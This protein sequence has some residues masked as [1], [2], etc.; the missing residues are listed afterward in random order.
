M[1]SFVESAVRS[2]IAPGTWLQTPDTY[3]SSPFQVSTIDSDGI[4]LPFGKKKTPTRVTWECLEGI[5]A[6]LKGKE[7]VEIGTVYD[8]G[9]KPDTLDGYLEGWI[10]RGTAGWVAA[11]LEKAAIVG[12]NR[13]RP[14]RVRL[15]L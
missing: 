6:F 7:W 3:K 9:A 12:I 11:V 15:K 10:N 14:M 8:T 1:P 13:K 4:V 5:P 2:Q